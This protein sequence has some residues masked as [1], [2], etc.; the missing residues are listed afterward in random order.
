MAEDRLIAE[1]KG[2]GGGGGG[3]PSISLKPWCA[4]AARFGPTAA[5]AAAAAHPYP[6]I[7]H[8]AQV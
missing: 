8:P 7:P 2:R 4:P 6:L 1:R 5:A 3:V